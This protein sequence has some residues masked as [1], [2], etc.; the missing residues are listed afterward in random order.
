[1]NIREQ[2]R[3]YLEEASLSGPDKVK[4]DTLIFEQGLLDSMGLLFLVQFL[5]DD[6][7]I[8]IQD[9][10]LDKDNFDSINAIVAFV[11]RK[12]ELTEA[13]SPSI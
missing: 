1:M 12:L 5:N 13:P 2:I 4:D 9:H 11:N 7:K 3:Q 10:E 8:V 6:F